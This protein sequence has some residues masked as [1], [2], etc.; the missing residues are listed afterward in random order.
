MSL[1]GGHDADVICTRVPR[2][3]DDL[4]WALWLRCSSWTPGHGRR[5][6]PGPDSCQACTA[7]SGWSHICHSELSTRGTSYPL[8]IPPVI[9]VLLPFRF[10]QCHL[11][12][13]VSQLG[14]IVSAHPAPQTSCTRGS[15]C[16]TWGNTD[17]FNSNIILILWPFCKSI[18]WPLHKLNNTLGVHEEHLPVCLP[19][20]GCCMIV[21]NIC[22]LQHERPSHSVVIT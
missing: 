2:G 22:N 8:Q 11:A 4:L 3:R 9:T 20:Q 10:S 16:G 15:H 12:G 17:A 5:C 14:D 6:T 19:L 7:L 13:T 21:Q 1:L 18:N